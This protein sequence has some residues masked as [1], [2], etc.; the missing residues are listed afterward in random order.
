MADIPANSYTVAAAGLTLVGLVAWHLRPRGRQY[1][2]RDPGGASAAVQG[3]RYGSDDDGDVAVPTCATGRMRCARQ[4]AWY[5]KSK[6]GLPKR[7]E[8]N[9]EMVSRLARDWLRDRGLRPSHICRVAPIA[10]A[11]VFVPSADD[12][13]ARQIDACTAAV[14]AREAYEAGWADRRFTWV[15]AIRDALVGRRAPTVTHLMR[16]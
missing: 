7:T 8:A 1:C 5:V 11:L 3:Y 13:D 6:V 14:D 15:G 10:T 9:R 16:G 4:C 12:V 2:V